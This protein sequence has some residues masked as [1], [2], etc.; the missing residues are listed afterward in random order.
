MGVDNRKVY[1]VEI[2]SIE[3]TMVY[4]KAESAELAKELVDFDPNWF[5]L[6]PVELKTEVTME[7]TEADLEG[8][9]EKIHDAGEDES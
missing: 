8:T 6:E 1:A 3:Q 9:G 5:D 4:V 2:T 7:M